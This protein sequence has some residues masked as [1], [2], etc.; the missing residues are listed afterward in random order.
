MSN[1]VN[2]KNILNVIISVS[3][4]L[5]G[6][7]HEKP[8]LWRFGNNT[9]TDQPAHLRSLISAF[10]IHLLETSIFKLALSKISIL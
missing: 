9:S 7:R 6:P 2:C 5:Y 10:V 3:E 8:C 4:T 1:T